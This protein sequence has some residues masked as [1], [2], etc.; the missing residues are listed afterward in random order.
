[1][2]PDEKRAHCRGERQE[3]RGCAA[4]LDCRERDDAVAKRREE[5]SKVAAE[6]AIY[7]EKEV[8]AVAA[9]LVRFDQSFDQRARAHCLHLGTKDSAGPIDVE[10]LALDA[11]EGL[12]AQ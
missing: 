7:G 10:R 12:A 1:M 8:H 9:P 2:A 4:L 6:L 11:T 3:L 5:I